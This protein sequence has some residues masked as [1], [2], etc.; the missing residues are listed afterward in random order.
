MHN[1]GCHET[2]EKYLHPYVW[3]AGQMHGDESRYD[4]DYLRIRLGD[5]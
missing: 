4:P 1:D 2:P 5:G 3:N